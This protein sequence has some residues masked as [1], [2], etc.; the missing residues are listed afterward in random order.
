VIEQ[1]PVPAV[2]VTVAPD[3]EHAVDDPAEYVIA[4]EPADV[5][6]TVCVS[7]NAFE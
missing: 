3:T 4:P 7:P 1:V 6:V 5:A 2:I